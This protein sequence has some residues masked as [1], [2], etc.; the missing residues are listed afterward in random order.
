MPFAAIGGARATSA[1]RVAP[2]DHPFRCPVHS[3]AAATPAAARL[4][5]T[6][7]VYL[8]GSSSSQWKNLDSMVRRRQ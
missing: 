2:C 8:S 1:A 6:R 4:P 3:P 5:I 7:P